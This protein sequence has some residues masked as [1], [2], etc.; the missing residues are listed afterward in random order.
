MPFLTSLK[1]ES[2]PPEGEATWRLLE[3]LVYVTKDNLQIIVPAGYVHDLASVPRW[4]WR[5]VRP[6]HPTARRPAVVHDYI[7]TDL[8]RYLTKKQADNIFYEA[9][10]EEG[11]SKFLAWIMYKAVSIGGKGN[12]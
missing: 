4:A 3:H 11:T 5:I 9:L 1:M 12:W 8:T 7:Y 2:I 6:D 10:L